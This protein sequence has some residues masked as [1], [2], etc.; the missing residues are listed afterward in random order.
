[1]GNNAYF[2]CGAGRR[3][4]PPGVPPVSERELLTGCWDL[5]VLDGNGASRLAALGRAPLCRTVL[6]PMETGG[7]FLRARQVVG[8]G[9]SR[10]SSLTLSGLS[11]RPV[12]CV[13][14][15]LV[16][17]NGAVIE[18]QDIPLPLWWGRLPPEEL[19][20]TA[21]AWL[22]ATGGVGGRQGSSASRVR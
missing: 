21:G 20:L 5:L 13:Q 9:L 3:F 4:L 14:R 6:L 16:D 1:M 11:P 17:A 10:R 7:A 15:R 8:C 22:L 18:P 19:L 12:L 2:S